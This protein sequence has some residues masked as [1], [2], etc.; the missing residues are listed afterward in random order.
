LQ[1]PA[2]SE[3]SPIFRPCEGSKV[4]WGGAKVL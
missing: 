1:K 2:K 3:R 4:P